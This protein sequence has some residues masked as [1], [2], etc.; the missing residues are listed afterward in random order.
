MTTQ[1]T[2]AAQAILTDTAQIKADIE[3]I[4][5]LARTI[6]VPMQGEQASFMDVILKLLN[7]IVSG[8]N[9]LQKSVEALH[10]RF[11]QPG[12]AATL[13]RVMEGD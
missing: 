8:I 11:E 5:Q 7:M 4:L 13:Q 6:A 3:T 1:P 10:Q 2:P 9:D 12:I